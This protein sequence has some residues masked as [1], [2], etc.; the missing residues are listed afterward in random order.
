MT[1]PRS[2]SAGRDHLQFPELWEPTLPTNRAILDCFA[3]LD[4]WNKTAPLL[5]WKV[6]E[7]YVFATEQFGVWG[8]VISLQVYSPS[9]SFSP[10]SPR[11]GNSR[12]KSRPQPGCLS[13]WICHADVLTCNQNQNAGPPRYETVPVTLTTVDLERKARSLAKHVTQT[14]GE[15]WEDLLRGITNRSSILGAAS[16]PPAVY[17]EWFTRIMNLP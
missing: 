15:P 8:K 13:P 9:S 6:R 3:E 2:H 14:G 17:A 7:A 10:F 16:T 4:G 5:G 11:C 12:S 1:S